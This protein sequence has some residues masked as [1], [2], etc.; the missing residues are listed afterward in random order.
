MDR[1][2]V[3]S[4]VDP[5]IPFRGADWCAFFDGEEE[6]GPCGWGATEREAMQDLIDNHGDDE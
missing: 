6:S 1:K 3:T 2:I 4:F 5:P